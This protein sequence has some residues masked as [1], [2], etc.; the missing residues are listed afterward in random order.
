[1]EIRI[2]KY[3][4]VFS[5]EAKFILHSRIQ[6]RKTDTEQGGIVLGKLIG[7]KIHILKLSVPTELDSSSRMNFVRHRLSAQIVIEHEFYNS[8]GQITYLGEWHTHPEPIPSPSGID[9]DMIKNQ[10]SKNKIHTDFLVLLIQGLS[11]LYIGVY[12]KTE[13]SS[14][15]CQNQM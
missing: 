5:A 10:F 8:N 9:I 13:L 3:E 7:N 14:I 4:I 15:I 6:R 1:M 2:N 12:S 11:E